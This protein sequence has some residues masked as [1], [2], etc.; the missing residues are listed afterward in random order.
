MKERSWDALKISVCFY[1]HLSYTSKGRKKRRLPLV[2]NQSSP[3]NDLNRQVR[4]FVTFQP[5]TDVNTHFTPWDFT[6]PM[7][8][9]MPCPRTCER[10]S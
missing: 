6:F 1:V 3:H 9:N 10:S 8:I 5:L 2:Q 4:L 7:G